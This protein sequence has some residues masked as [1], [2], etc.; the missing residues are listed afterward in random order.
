MAEPTLN[1]ET[2]KWEFVL[3]YYEKGKRKQIRRRGFKTKREAKDTLITIQQEVQ[4]NEYIGT[5]KTTVE[6]FVDKWLKNERVHECEDATFYNNTLYLKNHVK[7]RIGF[8]QMQ[9]M[10]AETCQDFV[11]AMS[12]EGYARNT[13][14][15]VTTMLKLAFDRAVVYKVIKE[16]YMRQVKLPR[17]ENKEMPVWSTDQINTFLHFTKGK[18][19]Y[20]A[21]AIALFTGMR[22]GEILG[23]RWKDVDFNK[24]VISVNQTLVNY[25]KNIKHG[26]KTKSGVRTISIPNQLI[27][28]LID[29][30]Q[31]YEKL[32]E[33][34]GNDFIDLD[35]VIFNERNGKFIFPG[36]L[37]KSYMRD[38]KAAGLPHIPF[39]SMRH[40]HA[41]MLIQKNVNVKLISE[42]LGH[43]KIGITLDTY[44]HVTPNMQ[45]EVASQI[46]ELISI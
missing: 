35:L 19:R 17:T 39:H 3:D 46:D 23:L 26:A 45:Q 42:R 20:C 14:D 38:V 6:A 18:K 41:T 36:N 21:Y 44:S 24:K 27:D 40:S 2:K 28:I 33:K 9:K 1:K 22:Q 16:N 30:R 13:I 34:L 12:E 32:K 8:I 11:S 25:G 10:D 7:P 4:Q 43:S 31:S 5:N 29:Q 15:R 37:T